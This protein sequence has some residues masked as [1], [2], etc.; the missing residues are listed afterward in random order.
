MLVLSGVAVV[1]LGLVVVVWIALA[2]P[3]WRP[4]EVAPL[5][6]D[7]SFSADLIL[8]GTDGY[9]AAG[10]LGIREPDAD[11]RC[12]GRF[13]LV[14]LDGSGSPRT[15]I[16]ASGLEGDRW[17]ANEVEALVSDDQGGWLL[18]G[19][20]RSEPEPSFDV[21]GTRGERLTLRVSADGEPKE[22]FGDIGLL[23]RTVVV[24]RVHGELVTD[25]LERV[26]EEGEVRADVLLDADSVAST[27]TNLFALDEELVVA[28]RDFG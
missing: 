12:S 16:V 18:A 26:T 24:G 2:H 22:E 25:E 3:F 5:A 23:H 6:P 1:A 27:W 15:A 28:I 19:V 8:T 7:A 11:G 13:A 21:P 17:C 20:G 9:V 14:E 10:V 4:P